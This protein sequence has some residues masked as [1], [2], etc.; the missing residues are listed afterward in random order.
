MASTTS[1]PATARIANVVSQRSTDTAEGNRGRARAIPREFET[2]DPIWIVVPT[3]VSAKTV[4]RPAFG[5]IAGHVVS[6]RR[7][8]RKCSNNARAI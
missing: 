5:P 6:P 3:S 7:M 1:T 2:G 8:A 4:G